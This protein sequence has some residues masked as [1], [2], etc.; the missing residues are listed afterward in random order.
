MNTYTNT[1][2]ALKSSA[3]GRWHLDP[4]ACMQPCCARLPTAGPTAV[5]DVLR[6]KDMDFTALRCV[7]RL[8]PDS[9]RPG[10]FNQI[11]FPLPYPLC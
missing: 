9:P 7:F 4:N 5:L 11:K 10:T 1:P 6:D 3:L 8:P 2:Y